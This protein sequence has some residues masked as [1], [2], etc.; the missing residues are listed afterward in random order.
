[1]NKKTEDEKRSIEL[2]V[3][4]SK[5]ELLVLQERSKKFKKTQAKYIRES[6]LGANFELDEDT[7]TA[8]RAVQNLGNNINQIAKRLNEGE[9]FPIDMQE[10]NRQIIQ[11]IERL[12]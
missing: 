5:K 2:K 7:R 8:R 9:R 3:R 4:V 1:M 6:A 10:L 12:K 11:A